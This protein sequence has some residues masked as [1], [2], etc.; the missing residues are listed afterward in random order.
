MWQEFGGGLGHCLS[1]RRIA[2]GSDVV[3]KMGV[4]CN[5]EVGF[6]VQNN[7]GRL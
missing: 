5:R 4:D 1:K 6:S 7:R 3:M 2:N